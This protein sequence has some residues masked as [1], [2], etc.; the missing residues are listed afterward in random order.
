[1]YEADLKSLGSRIV[2]A[3]FDEAKF[4]IFIHW[5]L[6]SVPGF[7]PGGGNISDAFKQ[8]Y[9]RAIVMVPYTEWYENAIKAP[10]TPSAAF[11]LKNYGDAP[12][13]AFANPF[14]EGLVHWNPAEWARLFSQ[15]GA[16]YVV[17]VVKHHDGYCLWPSNVKNLHRPGWNTQRDL[18]GELADA[19]RAQGLRF[20]IYYSGGIDWS[21]NREPLLTLGDFIGSMPGGDYPAY[22]LAQVRELIARYRPS[23]LWNDISW[24]TGFSDL[25]RLF[26]DYYNEVPDGVVNDRWPHAGLFTKLMRFSV[27]RRLFDRM[28]KRH[29]RKKP[30][31]FD[32]IIP[33]V[34][35][36]SDFRTPEYVRNPRMGNKKWEATRGMSYSFG[37]NRNDKPADY[38][39]FETLLAD[40]IDGVAHGGNLLLNVGPRADG[41]IPVE[42]LERLTKFGD[43]LRLNGEAIY[44]T[45]PHES[46]DA[47]TEDGLPVR[48]TRKGDVLNLIVLGTVS[49]P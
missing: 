29:I 46:P 36:H 6:F 14:K 26:A 31:T 17:M 19:V 37:F 25:L 27:V 30:D 33:P 39:P 44:G 38:T 49:D 34:V 45:V 13:E 11:H 32:G 4:G 41:H 16:K 5:G 42:Q 7:A 40:F 48:V 1:M 47:E 24:P 20:G 3:W 43:W 9:D 12:Y 10:D 35:P 15:A 18:V 2:P 8:D 23:V 28:V 22:A 21:F